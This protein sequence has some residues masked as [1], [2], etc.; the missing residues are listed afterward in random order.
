M[1]SEEETSS[2]PAEFSALDAAGRAIG[3]F[4]QSS[5][6]PVYTALAGLVVLAWAVFAA[7]A[8]RVGQA[9][10]GLA[11]GPG[12]DLARWLPDFPLPRWLE[13]FVAL[14]LVPAPVSGQAGFLL[15]AVTMW[16]LMAL[17]MM[18]PSALPMIRT[19]CEIAD[20]AARKGE[21]VVHPIVLVSGY[22]AVWLAFSALFGIAWASASRLLAPNGALAPIAAIPA[23]TA[24]GIAGLYQFSGLKE[25][26]LK[27][28]R[29][30]FATL[31]SNWS[32][33]PIAIFRLGLWQGIWCVGCCWALMLVMLAVG[34]M[35]LM[36]MALLSILAVVEKV[37]TGRFITRISGAI[38]LVWAAALLLLSAV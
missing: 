7:M 13:V 38:L 34:M 16:F 37:R 4:A 29:N 18:L 10:P 12:G 6:L 30:P 11:L 2:R 32:T 22:L 20:T 26:C 1:A 27:K 15:A 5:R 23:A 19:Y 35:N 9:T 21:K 3:A 25:V 28:C 24:L 33:R 17:A 31:F 8:A 14:C 36:W